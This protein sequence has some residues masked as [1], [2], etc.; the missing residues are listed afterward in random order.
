[1]ENTVKD[2]IAEIK[3][4][5]GY[6]GDSKVCELFENKI[7]SC[8]NDELCLWFAAH[9]DD[10]DIKKH[11]QVIIE[12]G[13]VKNN[14]I[15]SVDNEDA[16]IEAHSKIIIE[17]GNPEYNYLFAE[18]FDEIDLKAHEKVVNTEEPSIPQAMFV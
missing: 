6:Y 9:I 2:I 11:G 15:F 16:D 7:L 3:K 13:D 12:N 8:K 10:A 14:F 1:M 5:I 17:S 18:T 4:Y